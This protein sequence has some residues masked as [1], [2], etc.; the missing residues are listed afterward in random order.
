MSTD[1]V[2]KKVIYYETHLEMELLLTCR[3]LL[4]PA[5]EILG[6]LCLLGHPT[7]HPIFKEIMHF[8]YMTCMA[9]P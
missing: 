3:K 6:V 2:Q 7:L 5:V 9:T 8:H 4:S 1:I